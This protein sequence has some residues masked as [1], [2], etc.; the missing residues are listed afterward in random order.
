MKR[1]IIRIVVGS[2]LILLQIMSMIGS[3]S[4]GP[5]PFDSLYDFFVCVGYY[6]VG[7]VGIVL[8]AFGFN[9][10][11]Q[12]L[13]SGI[14]LHQRNGKWSTGIKWGV[15]AITTILLMSYLLNFIRLLAVERLH[16]DVLLI[17]F[18]ALSFDVYLLFYLYKK[19]TCLFSTSL[20]C[21][22]AAHLYDVLN[23]MG[24]DF[25]VVLLIFRTVPRFI[26]GILY[27]TIASKLYM[28]YFSSKTIKVCGWIVLIMELTDN[29]LFSAL[30]GYGEYLFVL[31]NIIQILFI[32][33]LFLYLSVFPMNTLEEME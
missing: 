24:S 13:F 11:T 2:I 28:E 23:L 31:P 33:S 27:I 21:I 6:A 29:I 30:S 3:R 9:A 16:I 8:L 15:F 19:P 10:Y 7:I 12:G 4:L 17:A 5:S 18:A 1:G 32:I 22:G 14:V 20:I 26:S 25:G